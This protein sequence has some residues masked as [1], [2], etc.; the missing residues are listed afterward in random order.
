M[1]K[2]R[3]HART[4]IRAR[5]LI[6]DADSAARHVARSALE[7]DGHIVEEAPDGRSACRLFEESRPD[8]VMLNFTVPGTSAGEVCHLIRSL[9]EGGLT[10]FLI[11]GDPNDTELETWPL[12]AGL[13]DFLQRPINVA[14][15][16]N[17]VR[18]ML[19]A[20][21]TARDLARSEA[22]TRAL[23]SAIPDL[24]FQVSRD[25]TFLDYHPGNSSG[26][27]TPPT[28]FL[29]KRLA[30]VFPEDVATRCYHF[31]RRALSTSQP[32]VFEYQLKS[33]HGTHSDFEARFVLGGDDRVLGIVRD[34][35]HRRTSNAALRFYAYH[36]QL[37]KL[38]NRLLFRERLV[39]ALDHARE[40]GDMLAVVFL[41]IDRF[42]Q[43]NDTFGHNLGD[44]ALQHVAAQLATA[45]P[46]YAS[47]LETGDCDNAGT[48]AR[49]GGDE[50]TILIPS[51]ESR[52]ELDETIDRLTASTAGSL[53][54][55]GQEVSLTA[56]IGV[57]VFPLD[58]TDADTLLKNAD[59]ALRN[60]KRAGRNSRRT[61]RPDMNAGA[62]EILSLEAQLR[63]ALKRHEFQPYFQPTFDVA[64][65]RLRGA[66]AL[67]RWQHP[68]RGLRLPS[69][70]LPLA[71]EMGLSVQIGDQ[72]L[73]LICEQIATWLKTIGRTVPV[74]LN[75]SDTEFRQ[76]GLGDRIQ[77]TA[78]AHGL[79]PC[80]LEVEITE[81]VLVRD[82]PAARELLA[83]LHDLGMRVAIDDFGT[84]YS[85]LSVLKGLPIDTLKVDRSFISDITSEPEGSALTA[86]IIHM[87]HDLGMTVV[88]EGVETEEQLQL[89]KQMECD[90]VQGFLFSRA[91]SG[92]AFASMLSPQTRASRNQPGPGY[93]ELAVQANTR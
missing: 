79:N 33:D 15:L 10:P 11:V 35:S 6:V 81:R 37:T 57:S 1:R 7:H 32:Q 14:V 2:I 92:D 75:L 29:G 46:G 36:D 34:V 76:A 25:G 38:P 58:G 68:T 83:G 43:V 53:E 56:S 89:L 47:A 80:T 66:E 42:K 90:E 85:S 73:E 27:I 22:R 50:F 87:G 19:R 4:D 65:G 13:T 17:R 44:L 63:R 20:R 67:V 48:V 41:G 26:E 31:V 52:A 77:R 39:Q 18:N 8:L 45:V 82:R 16:R 62:S 28:K 74:A 9:P 3:L 71:E 78:A 61:Y 70:F 12:G 24:M 93:G 51:V 40:K 23:V 91:V 55:D 21:R 84:G 54:I 72:L 5:V 60:A 86:A 49:L 69:S 59:A 88:A 30:D 64:T